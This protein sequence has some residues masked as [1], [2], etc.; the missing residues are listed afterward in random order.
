MSTKRYVQ[1]YPQGS[2]TENPNAHLQ[3]KGY[4]VKCSYHGILDSNE[5]ATATRHEQ[6]PDIIFSEKTR[7]KEYTEV[8]KFK[9]KQN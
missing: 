3:Q 1:E 2:K 4:A 8:K 6:I 5:K 9:N 7:H